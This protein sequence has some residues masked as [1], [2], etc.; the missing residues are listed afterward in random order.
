[1]QIPPP[2]AA[3]LV[4]SG[5]EDAT[6]SGSLAGPPEIK[7]ADE[8]HDSPTGGQLDQAI[9]RGAEQQFRMQGAGHRLQVPLVIH[10]A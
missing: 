2:E 8:Q 6:H 10:G 5:P 4:H 3:A 9:P 1:M 7:A